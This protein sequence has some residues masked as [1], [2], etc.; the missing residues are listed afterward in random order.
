MSCYTFGKLTL[1]KCQSTLLVTANM[2]STGLQA[3]QTICQE[4]NDML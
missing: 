1:P 4:Q 2:H 3:R